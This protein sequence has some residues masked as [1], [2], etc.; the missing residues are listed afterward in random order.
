LLFT[1][2]LEFGIIGGR[3]EVGNIGIPGELFTGGTLLTL[4]IPGGATYLAFL[5][6]LAPDPAAL[7]IL[8]PMLNDG[9]G[10]AAELFEL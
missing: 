2:P 8:P 9:G 6:L 5:R 1:I 10:G 4:L 3:L 7:T